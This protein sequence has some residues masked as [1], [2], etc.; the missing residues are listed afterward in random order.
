LFDFQHFEELLFALKLRE[1]L[2]RVGLVL[3]RA[4]WGVLPEGQLGLEY[5]LEDNVFALLQF[6]LGVAKPVFFVPV[7][8]EVLLFDS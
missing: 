4:A 8:V 2:H 6:D 3:Q 5:I 7:V 1:F